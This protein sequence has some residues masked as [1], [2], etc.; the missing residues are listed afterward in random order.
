[1]LISG[2]NCRWGAEVREPRQNA[3]LDVQK[4]PFAGS[5][6]RDTRMSADSKSRFN[7]STVA[8]QQRLASLSHC[9]KRDISPSW[10]DLGLSGPVKIRDLWHHKHLGALT[11]ILP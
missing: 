11:E 8:K 5:V 3:R 4:S 2:K 7:G 9:I 1:L 10:T 6:G